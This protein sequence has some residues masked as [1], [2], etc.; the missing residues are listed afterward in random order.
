MKFEMRY[1]S[2]EVEVPEN[3]SL[4][5]V[6]DFSNLFSLFKILR[7]LFDLL[8]EKLMITRSLDGTSVASKDVRVADEKAT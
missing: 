3:I 1:E 7:R 5:C 4:G 2:R 8:H 6:N